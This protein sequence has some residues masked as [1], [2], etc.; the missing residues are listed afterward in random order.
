MSMVM[1]AINTSTYIIT[2]AVKANCG[3]QYGR[4]EVSSSFSD[5][6]NMYEAE[7]VPG[8]GVSGIV[9]AASGR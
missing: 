4:S 3:A 7:R 2:P 1:Q 6:R 9:L 8:A 5:L